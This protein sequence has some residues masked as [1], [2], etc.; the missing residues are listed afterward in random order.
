[1]NE[2]ARRGFGIMRAMDDVEL[3]EDEINDLLSGE[4]QGAGWDEEDGY[5]WVS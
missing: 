3:T 1:M 2:P 5:E 4:D